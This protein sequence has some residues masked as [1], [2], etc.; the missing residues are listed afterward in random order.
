MGR[1]SIICQVLCLMCTATI[2]IALPPSAV[3]R[4]RGCGG[5]GAGRQE[6]SRKTAR[7]D[8]RAFLFQSLAVRL[9]NL[10]YSPHF[11]HL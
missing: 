8:A 4:V 11:P 9:F 3:G 2:L 1:Q 7:V 5:A 10:L 6:E